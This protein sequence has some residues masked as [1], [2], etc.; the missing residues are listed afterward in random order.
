MLVQ[1]SMQA[2]G[3]YMYNCLGLQGGWC[4]PGTAACGAVIV[5]LTSDA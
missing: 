4:V 5:Y 3:T 2:A 1:L